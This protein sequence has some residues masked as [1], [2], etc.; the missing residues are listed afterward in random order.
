MEPKIRII[1]CDDHPVITEGLRNFLDQ[2]PNM[3]VVAT[4]GCGAD[5]MEILSKMAVDIILLDINLPDSNGI[6]L[7][8]EI[9]KLYPNVKIIGFSNNNERSFIVRMLSN[10][11]S[12]YLVK[13][14]SVTEI[15]EAIERVFEGGIYFGT[16][17]Q[18]ALASLAKDAAEEIPP[19]T[20][21]EREVLHLLANGLSSVEIADKLF[22]TTQTVD[23]HRKNLMSKF[24]VNK[25]ITLVQKAK[26]L[27]FLEN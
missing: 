3:D 15:E 16:D 23:S 25:T 22:V 1:I 27:G 13:S 5:L 26:E 2:K 9:K 19:V 6:S 18:Q 14:A 12:G 21:R 7:C 4:V 10:N 8:A 11:A 17:A 24:S 20:K